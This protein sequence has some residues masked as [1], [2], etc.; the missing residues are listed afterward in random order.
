MVTLRQ[1]LCFKASRKVAESR[2]Y[3]KK[4]NQSRANARVL[5]KKESAD[6]RKAR[7]WEAK[8]R[9]GSAFERQRQ[10]VPK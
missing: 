9:N 6:L 3:K 5:K 1:T 10:N 7:N 4:A 2:K 8:K